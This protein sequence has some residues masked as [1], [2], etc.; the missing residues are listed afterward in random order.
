MGDTSTIDEQPEGKRRHIGLLDQYASEPDLAA[1]LGK[2]VRWLY[3]KRKNG[4]GP[5]WTRHGQ[6]ILY[7]IPTAREWLRS[8]EVNPRKASAY[9]R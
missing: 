5:R 7:H 4:T 9:N 8:L 3:H 1:D 2:S 6:T